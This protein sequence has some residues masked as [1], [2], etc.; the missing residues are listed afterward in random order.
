M[1]LLVKYYRTQVKQKSPSN[2][3]NAIKRGRVVH[4]AIEGINW[5]FVII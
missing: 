2:Q 5:K 1:I 3:D 4:V